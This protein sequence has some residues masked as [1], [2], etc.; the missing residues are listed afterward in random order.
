VTPPSILVAGVTLLACVLLAMYAL[1]G[2]SGAVPAVPRLPA[3]ALLSGWI[4]LALGLVAAAAWTVVDLLR[5]RRPRDEAARER[6]VPLWYLFVASAVLM[7]LTLFIGGLVLSFLKAPDEEPSGPQ[8]GVEQKS[9]EEPPPQETEEPRRL[10]DTRALS[11][12]LLVAAGTAA[13]VA[14]VLLVRRLVRERRDLARPEEE[15]LASLRRELS[16]GLR[17]SLEE[18]MGDRDYRR[19]IIACYARMEQSFA[20]AGSPRGEPETPLEFL[21]RVLGDPRL[22]TESGGSGAV[23]PALGELTELYEVA[24][25]S[26]HALREEDRSR[27]VSCLRVL[28]AAVAREAAL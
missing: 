11:I 6:S 1:P 7:V 22:T 20:R 28:D 21:E 9:E 16:A 8:Q 13:A 5:R 19:A 23:Q 18:I 17:L 4:L 24:R 12:A 10:A 25:F 26:E 27:A 15:A 2:G 14:T 3:W